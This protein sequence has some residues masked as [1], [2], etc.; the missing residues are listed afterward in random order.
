MFK[1]YTVILMSTILRFIISF[2][3]IDFNKETKTRHEST[4]T[5]KNSAVLLCKKLFFGTFS[6]E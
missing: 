6:T 2:S 3:E 5:S 1:P 4:V